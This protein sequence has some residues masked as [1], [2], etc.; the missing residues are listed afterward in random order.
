MRKVLVVAMAGLLLAAFSGTALA[1]EKVRLGLITPL[2]GTLSFGGN[3]VKNGV[4]LAIEE[5]KTLFGKEI[6]LVVADAPDSTAAVAE[7]ERLHSREGLN[8]VFGGYGSAL[9]E[10][11]QK[12]SEREKK[13]C[14]GVVNWSDKL[15]A[16]GL[17]YYYRF[18]ATVSMLSASLVDFLNKEAPAV[19][20]KD[21][22]DIIVVVVNGDLTS[23]VANPII[24]DLKKAGY[25]NI[26]HETYPSD[27]KDFTSLILK[28]RRAKPDILIPCQYTADGMAF[29]RQ[30]VAMDYEPA[31]A[32]GGGLIYDQPEFAD[33]GPKGAD[34]ILCTSFTNPAMNPNVAPGLR[35]FQEKYTK[36]FGH[37]PLT[38]ALSGYAGAQTYLKV[39]E[40]AGSLDVDVVRKALAE[41]NIPEG[42]TPAYWGMKFDETGQNVLARQGVVAQWK[43]GVYTVVWP[44]KF[45]TDKLE[46]P[47]KP[48]S[49]R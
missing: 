38:H 25:T 46:L 37:P 8:V 48:F 15:T 29:R 49:K 6:E 22:K 30:M 45:A 17:K 47:L 16:G 41:T 39:L 36:R 5:K 10:A 34:G 40:K 26:T 33:L 31:I 23:Y 18:A 44:A 42:E 7:M 12:V 4:S 9:E 11:W 43:K 35:E 32:V 27:L 28:I 1:A 24:A 20:K 13:L 14:L 3:E 21:K 2:T 19:L